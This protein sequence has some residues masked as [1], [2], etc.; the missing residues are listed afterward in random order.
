M[1]TS[2]GY[3]MPSGGNWTD[4]KREATK[5]AQ[6]GPASDASMLLQHFIHANGGAAGW[7]SGKGGGGNRAGKTAIIGGAARQAGRKLGGFLARVG[8]SGL[9]TALE[10]I[11]L[12]KLVGH[13]AS[14]ISMALLDVLAG[15]AS[16]LDNAA[17]RLA[18]A[19]LM[20]ELLRAD[21]P[22]A[23]VEKAFYQALDKLGVARIL[24]RFFGLYLYECFCRNFYEV[25]ARKVGERK[26]NSQ[27]KSVKSCIDSSLRAK[28]GTRD[29][30][31]IRW[32]GPE[33]RRMTQSILQETLEIFGG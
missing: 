2:K 30:T 10:D 17:A 24:T 8:S 3:T 31:L 9:A 12:S 26:A 21:K 7:A 20:K 15:P 28:I 13:T 5:F 23:A 22:F 33:G 14:E 27:L 25:W 18:L 11:G 6:S 19:A 29:P 4:L 16:T 1:G 32:D